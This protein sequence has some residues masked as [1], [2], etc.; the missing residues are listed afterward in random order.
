MAERKDAWIDL[1]IGGGTIKG[2]NLSLGP[3]DNP[4]HHRFHWCLHSTPVLD[5]TKR[6]D[7]PTIRDFLKAQGLNPDYVSWEI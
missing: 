3:I 7:N 1:T 5:P 4:P 6:I 2:P